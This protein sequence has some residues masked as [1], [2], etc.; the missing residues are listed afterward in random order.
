[1]RIDRLDHLVLTVADIPAWADVRAYAVVNG[2]TMKVV[3]D[4]VDDP[5][6]HGA[7]ALTL[8]L[9]ATYTGANRE[10]L[11]ASG[12]TATSGITL[13]GQTVAAGGTLGAPSTTPLTVG[14]STLS[15]SINAG[16][17]AIITLTK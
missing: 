7:T 16:S 15:L 8:S 13:G 10:N 1:M 6:S 2:S 4:D 11:T 5:A 9:G 17:A 14:G 12:L 3:L